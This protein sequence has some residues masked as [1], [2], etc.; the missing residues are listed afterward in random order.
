MNRSNEP[1]YAILHLDGSPLFLEVFENF[2]SGITLFEVNYETVLNTQEAFRWLEKE[3]FDLLISALMLENDYD[4]TLGEDFIIKAAK[5][6]PGLKIMAL[7]ASGKGAYKRLK[8]YVVHY[9]T[10][11]FRPSELEKQMAKII[12][13][14]R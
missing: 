7:T 10:K 6:Y 3:Q 4:T 1:T 2:M 5:R 11:A 13:A 12:K 14:P 8:E 9:E